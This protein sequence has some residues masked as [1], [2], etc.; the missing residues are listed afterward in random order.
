MVEHLP[1]IC[2]V[3]GLIPALQGE[4]IAKCVSNGS[5]DMLG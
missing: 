2:K 1:S 4:K 5:L 3:L